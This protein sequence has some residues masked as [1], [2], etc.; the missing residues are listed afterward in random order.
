MLRSFSRMLPELLRHSD[1]P[2][3]LELLSDELKEAHRPRAVNRD[4]ATAQQDADA[5]RQ[6]R[7][8]SNLWEAEE[9]P[10]DDDEFAAI[11]CL[12]PAGVDGDESLLDDA[13]F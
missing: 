4:D 10:C 1:K 9:D 8:S 6:P 11:D 13:G 12:F 7:R 3:M 5:H 2:H